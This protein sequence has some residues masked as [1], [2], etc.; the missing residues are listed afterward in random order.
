MNKYKYLLR[1]YARNILENI[2]KINFDANDNYIKGQ[3]FTY[4]E[5]LENIKHSAFIS[6]IQLKELGLDKFD[7]TKLLHIDI[8]SNKYQI[9]KKFINE[10]DPYDFISSGAP[11]DEFENEIKVICYKIES[12]NS[13]KDIACIV[14]DVFT[15]KFEDIHFS[16]DSCMGIAEKIKNGIE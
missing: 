14:S 5:I 9:V 13:I 8:N 2:G 16:I 7:S 3:F 15:K 10:W 11:D 6:K 12:K 1:E 4:Y